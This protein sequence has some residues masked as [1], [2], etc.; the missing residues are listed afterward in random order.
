V[1][2]KVYCAS[3][4]HNSVTVIDGESDSVLAIVAVGGHAGKLCYAGRPNSVYCATTNGVAVI[5]GE[6]NLVVH[7]IPVSLGGD[8]TYN[9]TRNALWSTNDSGV[10]VIDCSTNEVVAAF[11]VGYWP[12][13]VCCN[14]HHHKAYCSDD[15]LRY[16][17]IID[18]STYQVIGTAA[19]GKWVHSMCYDSVSDK[20]YCA[21]EQGN[22]VT[23]IDGVTNSVIRDIQVGQAPVALAWDSDQNRIFVANL[24][25]SSISVLRDSGGGIEE[26]PNAEVRTRNSVT[27]VRG[28]LFLPEASG[29]RPQVASLLDI[30]GRKVMC[31]EPGATDVRAL[32]PGVYFVREAQAQAQAQAIRKVVITR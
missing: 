7:T 20:L 30:S 12:R 3:S 21:A 27:V 26:M 2:N 31:L 29:L 9:E 15:S 23:V 18:D 11:R 24:N 19:V 6:S 32:A 10:V 8:I 25:S 16:V 1:N 17:T 22:R 28:V 5:D 4:H 13:M 14:P